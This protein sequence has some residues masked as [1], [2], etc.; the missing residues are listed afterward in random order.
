M[1]MIWCEHTGA[2]YHTGLSELVSIRYNTSY[3]H[4]GERHNIIKKTIYFEALDTHKNQIFRF[5]RRFNFH[6]P[7][8]QDYR[9]KAHSDKNDLTHIPQKRVLGDH[10]HVVFGFV[11]FD[12]LHRCEN[13]TKSPERHDDD[14]GRLK[15]I[16]R[17]WKIYLL[18][19]VGHETWAGRWQNVEDE[20]SARRQGRHE[21]TTKY[22]QLVVVVIDCHNKMQRL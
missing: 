11:T 6:L 15:V 18:K 17:R 10:S 12:G 22:L 21:W 14:N 9:P 16:K 19:S 5:I 4:S 20:V 3:D 2:V 7:R 1:S 8:T 13:E